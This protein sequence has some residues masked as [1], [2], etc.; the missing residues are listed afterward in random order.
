MAI[1]RHNVRDPLDYGLFHVEIEQAIGGTALQALV[2]RRG[3]VRSSDPHDDAVFNPILLGDHVMTAP[4]FVY[5]ITDFLWFS[6]PY[7]LCGIGM[8]VAGAATSEAEKDWAAFLT[9][10]SL[11]WQLGLFIVLRN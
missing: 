7:F 9:T 8:L 2:F 5:S 1:R 6:I 3:W 4:H 11:L 10:V